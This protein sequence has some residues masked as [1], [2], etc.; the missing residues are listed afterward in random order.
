[1]HSCFLRHKE[2][3]SADGSATPD[4]GGHVDDDAGQPRPAQSRSS[5]TRQRG[6][7]GDPVTVVPCRSGQHGSIDVADVALAGGELLDVHGGRIGIETAVRDGYVPQ[8]VVDVLGHAG[9]VAADIEVR[10]VP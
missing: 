6:N 5:R 8:R 10:A 9:G 1:M 4:D 3:A 7:Q 2:A